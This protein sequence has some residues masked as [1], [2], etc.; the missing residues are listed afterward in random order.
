[1]QNARPLR[2]ARDPGEQIG[3]RVGGHPLQRPEIRLEAP[4]A[5]VP[6]PSCRRGWRGPVVLRPFE[7]NVLGVPDVLE[8]VPLADPHVLDLLPGSVR[9][10]ARLLPAQGLGQVRE[11]LLEPDVR[12]PASQQPP[13]F[14]TQRRVA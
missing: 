7:G 2:I 14:L 10:A 8:D 1:M 6:C 13:Y 11:G 9:E 5:L 4:Y 12:V 3:R